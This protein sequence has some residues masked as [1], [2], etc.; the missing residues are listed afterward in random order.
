MVSGSK[1]KERIRVAVDGDSTTWD[2]FPKVL[3][4]LAANGCK[5]ELSQFDEWK[6]Y[7]KLGIPS[8]LFWRGFAR[9]WKNLKNCKLM[10]E[11]IPYH[12]T[13][14]KAQ[15]VDCYLVTAKWKGFDK[16]VREAVSHHNL[17]FAGVMIERAASTKHGLGFKYIL[18]DSPEV[19]KAC[20]KVGMT[21][22]LY[23][24]ERTPWNHGLVKAVRAGEFDGYSGEILPTPTW[25]QFALSMFSLTG[26]EVYV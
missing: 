21:V 10:E 3:E 8:K 15:G 17:E 22:F 13:G 12:I 26:M 14:L 24:N 5:R 4:F 23:S 1:N 9:T 20:A 25:K 16:Y 2:V 6:A 11:D 19:A 18:D 7:E